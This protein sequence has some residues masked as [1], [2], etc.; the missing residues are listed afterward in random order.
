MPNYLVVRSS[1]GESV[2]GETIREET[3]AAAT[4]RLATCRSMSDYPPVAR[5]A[6]ERQDRLLAEV[7]QRYSIRVACCAGCSYCCHGIV[8]ARAHEILYAAD[9]IRRRYP[10]PAL[11][12]IV[13]RC[14]ERHAKIAPLRTAV[15][16]RTV[17]TACPLLM[18]GLCG[19]Y[20]GRPMVC[21]THHSMSV[22]PCRQWL[23]RSDETSHDDHQHQA[24]FVQGNSVRVGAY[25]AYESAGFDATLYDLGCA[26]YEALTDPRCAR[27]WK[28]GKKAFS[29]ACRALE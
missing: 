15:E 1:A 14:R 9:V 17:R 21:R 3:R 5:E 22:D 7:Q 16:Q 26:L 6:M 12:A 18:D 24:V 2:D 11:G 23:E 8:T 29:I 19:A 4:A 28:D 25:A 27:R 20:A 10:E 13:E